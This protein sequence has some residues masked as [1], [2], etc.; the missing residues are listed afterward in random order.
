MSDLEAA[1]R[2][3]QWKGKGKG[4]VALQSRLVPVRL[5]SGELLNVSVAPMDTI[6][7]VRIRVSQLQDVAVEC[8]RLVLSSGREPSDDEAFPENEGE[9]L[10]C[11]IQQGSM[12]QAPPSARSS[13]AS[14][15]SSARGAVALAHK[16][17]L[18]KR[19]FAGIFLLL[20]LSCVSIARH[21]LYC[22]V[23]T[24]FWTAVSANWIVAGGLAALC[25]T[26]P[27]S[28]SL[29]PIR[30]SKSIT[31]RRAL[32]VPLGVISLVLTLGLGALAIKL[33][34]AVFAEA[35]SWML[36]AGSGAGGLAFICVA[37]AYRIAVHFPRPPHT[38][39]AGSPSDSDS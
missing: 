21:G 30:A 24:I 33:R 23:A 32:V 17:K 4:K 29:P 25:M 14:S 16:A 11:L 3:S 20:L 7:S 12:N 8:V 38:L 15:S 39:D 36:G 10:Q 31:E 34:S 26:K 35:T 13:S 22:T 37:T 2:S 19:R 18:R 5:M 1:K 9:E 28:L 6:R 27:K